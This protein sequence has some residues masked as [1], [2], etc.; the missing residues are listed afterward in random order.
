MSSIQE[1][2]PYNGAS[3]APNAPV[4][5][6]TCDRQWDARFNVQG[7]GDLDR[8]L[9]R[10]A[11]EW[12]AGKFRYV[13]VGGVEVG[14][15]SNQDDYQIE[16]VHCALVY[17]NRVTK[18]SILKNLG[19]KQGNGYY[20]VPRNRSLPYS[21][22][23]SHHIKSHSKV[24]YAERVGVLFLWSEVLWRLFLTV[25]DVLRRFATFCYLLL[26]FATACDACV[27]ACG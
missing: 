3:L 18:S 16:H 26:P 19:I 6:T 15:M 4:K 25:S 20:L 5:Y 24:V 27:G 10:V 8:L 11:S 7:E 13:L 21:G 2:V 14:T 23:R 1:H 12:N 17:N 22:W 9:E